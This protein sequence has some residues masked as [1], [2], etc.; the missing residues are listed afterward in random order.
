[1]SAAGS[2][3]EVLALYE[4]YGDHTYDEVVSQTAH[5]EQTA[6]RAVAAGS[7]DALVAA[8]GLSDPQ[9]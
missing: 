9:V 6:A 1:M 7:S 3:D 2:V 5:A 8:A 4:R